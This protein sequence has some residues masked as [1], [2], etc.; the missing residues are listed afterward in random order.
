[1][2]NP[3]DQLNKITSCQKCGHT[4]TWNGDDILC[5]FQTSTEF[6][7]N[8]KCGIISQIRDLCEA[9]IDKQDNRFH[10][11]SCDEQHYVTINID[12][13]NPAL[14]LWISW[15][16]QRGAIDAMWILSEQEPPRKPSFGDLEKILKHYEQILGDYMNNKIAF[17]VEDIRTKKIIFSFTE[18]KE[19]KQI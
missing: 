14:C 6:I 10:H 1:M 8:W 12:F 7:D 17:E 2:E 5:P 11:Q 13:L 3:V 18:K 16:K 15:Y 19:M 4:K 9:G